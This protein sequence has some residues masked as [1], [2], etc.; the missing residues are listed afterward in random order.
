LPAQIKNPAEQ[1]TSSI[2]SLLNLPENKI[3]IGIAA[4]TLAREIY[5]DVDVASY[6]AKLDSI[7]GHVRR[8]AKGTH[9]PDQRIR[10]LNTVILLHEKFQGTRDLSI[11]RKSEKYF[12]NR[13]LDSKRGNCF[14]M[15]VLYV[16]VAQRL[17]WPIY[18]VSVPDHSFVRYVDPVLKEQNIETT[19][20]GGYVPN[21]QYVK[22][23]M[24]SSKGRKSGAYL[25]TLT[26]REFLGDLVATNGIRFGQQ[27]Q[28]AK[29]AA[30]LQLATQLNP[31]LVGAWANLVNV[32][33]MIAKR[34]SGP[35]AKKYLEAAA[36]Y[37]KKLNELGFV[38]PK[39][40]PQFVSAGRPQ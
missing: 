15:P 29:A 22:D 3:D 35:E 36:K 26:Y 14:S 19:S 23:F 9:D 6:S 10:C 13:V 7:A 25:R 34:S 24:V 18:P 28:L 11:A 21:E 17:G 8:L 12:L 2:Q 5:P 1:S 16:A 4:L 39:D 32:N 27:G 40:V 33:R 30:Y 31:K 38:H 20:N 37:S